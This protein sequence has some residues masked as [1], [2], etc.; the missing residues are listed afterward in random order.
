MCCYVFPFFC[1]VC[2]VIYEIICIQSF[3][4][5]VFGSVAKQVAA[6]RKCLQDLIT[7]LAIAHLSSVPKIDQN[8]QINFLYHPNLLLSHLFWCIRT[9]LAS[10]GSN[11]K[12]T[13]A[14]SIGVQSAVESSVLQSQKT[15]IQ[16]ELNDFLLG[17]GKTI[18]KL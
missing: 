13:L 15:K 3:C 5:G 4:R 1:S 7:Y 17:F 9:I 18:K 6:L 2:F 14:H 16:L 11:S 12:D 8:R 10:I